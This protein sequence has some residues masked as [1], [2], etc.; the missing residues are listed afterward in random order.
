[1]FYPLCISFSAQLFGKLFVPGCPPETDAAM[2]AMMRN[3][4][5]FVNGTARKV[6]IFLEYVALMQQESMIGGCGLL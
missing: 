1:M 4:N 5:T 2:R 3:H 6:T